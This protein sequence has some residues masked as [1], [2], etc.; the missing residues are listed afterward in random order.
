MKLVLFLAE[1]LGLLRVR[2][3]AELDEDR[4]CV[5]VANHKKGGLSD[6]AER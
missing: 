1:E 5:V 6:G 4:G 2:E 3:K